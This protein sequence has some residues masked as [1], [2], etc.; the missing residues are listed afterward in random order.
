MNKTYKLIFDLQNCII[1]IKC[2][3]CNM[4]SYNINDAREKYC[5]Y[6]H[7]FHCDEVKS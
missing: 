3:R 7:E 4:I 2:L 5:G 1:G 6:C